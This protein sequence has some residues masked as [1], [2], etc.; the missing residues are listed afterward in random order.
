[1]NGFYLVSLSELKGVYYSTYL[2]LMP[3]FRDKERTDKGSVAKRIYEGRVR[4]LNEKVE[5]W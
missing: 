2:R 1:M 4:T 5:L 3:G